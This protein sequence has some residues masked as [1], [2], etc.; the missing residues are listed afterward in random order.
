MRYIN[1]DVLIGDPEVQ[2]LINAAEDARA[3]VLSEA[4]PARRQTLVERHRD[5]WVAF[6]PHLARVSHNKCWYTESL[7]PGTDDD[8]DHFRPKGR[9]AEDETHGGY[10]WEAL[11][12][13]NFRFSCHRA[14]R[15]RA[16]PDTG[17]T[18]GKGDHF[19][20]L[21]EEDRCRT[22]A[23]DL[24][25]ER[26]MLLDPTDPTDPPLLTFNVDGSVALSSEFAGDGDAERRLEAS[27][28]YLHLDWPAFME[29]RKS[30]YRKV[31]TKIN[32]GERQEGRA[33]SGD[34]GSR[35]ALKTT[36]RDLIDLTREDRPYSMAAKA[37]VAMFRGIP[38]VRR[39]VLPHCS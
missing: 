32:D 2:R 3:E 15:V 4:E 17:R 7:N 23:D 8:V 20:L 18:H 29:Q 19:P 33:R 6:R 11:N 26:P 14:N 28:V 1:Y 22:P 24:G 9:L 36:A 30:L 27:R 5:R 39:A 21:Q 35:E 31:I 10:W 34:V 12:W 25:R 37:Y 16:N 13:R 38:W